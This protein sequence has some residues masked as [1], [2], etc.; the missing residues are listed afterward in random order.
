MPLDMAEYIVILESH[1]NS[2]CVRSTL[3]GSAKPWNDQYFLKRED[4]IH[5]AT[6][7]Q[8]CE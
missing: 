2:L 7:Q 8:E 6:P 5:A 1:I 3:P 4:Q